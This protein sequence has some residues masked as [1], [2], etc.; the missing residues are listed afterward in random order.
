MRRACWSSAAAAV[1]AAL[2]RQQPQAD[3]QTSAAVTA[4]A[5]TA[6]A[7]TMTTVDAMAAAR[8]HAATAAALLDFEWAHDDDV[9]VQ[10]R[11]LDAQLTDESFESAARD[12]A[13]AAVVHS[14]IRAAA[15]GDGAPLTARGERLMLS[16]A[17]VGSSSSASA[18]TTT[19]AAVAGGT[20]ACG[21]HAD[22]DVCAAAPAEVSVGADADAS[23]LAVAAFAGAAVPAAALLQALGT[24]LRCLLAVAAADSFTTCGRSH[25]AVDSLLAAVSAAGASLA[26]EFAGAAARRAPC[27][28][29]AI[30]SAAEAIVAAARRLG[31][32]ADGDAD[33][34]RRAFDALATPR[35][36]TAEAVRAAFSSL[37]QVLADAR[38]VLAR[39]PE[40][41][42]IATPKPVSDVLVAVAK[43]CL[44]DLSGLDAVGCRVDVAALDAVSQ[45]CAALG[46][47]GMHESVLA[48]ALGAVFAAL[49]TAG[50]QLG[51]P[52]ACVMCADVQQ[53]QQYGLAASV[54]TQTRTMI[55][56]FAEA[57]LQV[58]RALRA[59]RVLDPALFNL[60]VPGD[61]E[62]RGS[63]LSWPARHLHAL[64]RAR[65]C[66]TAAL[67][68]HA[69]DSIALSA[70][71]AARAS[72]DPTATLAAALQFADQARAV[73]TLRA[74]AVG[75]ARMRVQ[76]ARRAL[77]GVGNEV[78]THVCARVRS[79]ADD[80]HAL[81]MEQQHVPPLVAVQDIEHQ[82]PAQPPAPV[83]ASAPAPAPA[84]Q[85]QPAPAVAADLAESLRDARVATDALGFIKSSP[86]S[87]VERLL[88]LRAILR[89]RERGMYDAWRRES[90]AL[91]CVRSLASC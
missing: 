13:Y 72:S 19:A 47:A 46:G 48:A 24:G 60:S 58:A 31:A 50:E 70:Q 63:V 40:S 9:A 20:C 78:R 49:R 90:G 11:E 85:P 69:A 65:L 10:L 81:Q 38:D 37:H 6:T 17:A 33:A 7:T 5:T 56:S 83:P 12:A 43:V 45:V 73:L 22:D 64:R 28:V 15:G 34:L 53:A 89:G 35:G 21:K 55:A 41:A 39:T 62:C 18:M 32:D 51:V 74:R 79:V 80:V 82:Q 1:V 67:L 42:A 30:A 2:A 76:D 77:L 54:R 57:H 14:S 3:P 66:E 25:A 68:A 23:S 16:V 36:L 86:R 87:T 84:T 75:D 61:R 44:R 8:R 59:L 71:R 4:A 29:H 26:L 91:R 88:Q 27:S 52:A